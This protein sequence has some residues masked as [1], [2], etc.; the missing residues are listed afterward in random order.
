MTERFYV[1]GSRIKQRG[2]DG[3]FT[4]DEV[5][6]ILNRQDNIKSELDK[7]LQ[8]T[9]LKLTKH[10]DLLLECAELF[11]KYDG[12]KLFD[13]EYI[14]FA[15]ILLKIQTLVFDPNEEV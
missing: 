7:E 5:C 3:W 9:R 15:E 8:L 11:R 2:V 1:K 10:K 12:R 14:I 4:V 13:L 6:E